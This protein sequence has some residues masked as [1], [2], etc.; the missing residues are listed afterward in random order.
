M[1]KFS[2]TQPPAP[3]R[4]LQ[5]KT[6]QDW[7]H[8]WPAA[9]SFKWSAVPLPVRMGVTKVKLLPAVCLVNI[10]SYIEPS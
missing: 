4:Q 2:S 8:V 3:P 6:D 7:T 1:M 10:L 5:M 9:A